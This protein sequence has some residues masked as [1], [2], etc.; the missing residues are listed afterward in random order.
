[1]HN[2]WN[3]IF[4]E[5]HSFLYNVHSMRIT[6]HNWKPPCEQE[7][8]GSTCAWF[9]HVC[10]QANV[11]FKWCQ[12]EQTASQ[13]DRRRDCVKWGGKKCRGALMVFNL[14]WVSEGWQHMGR[15]EIEWR[16]Y[17]RL[18]V[19]YC[20]LSLCLLHS[21]PLSPFLAHYPLYQQTSPWAAVKRTVLSHSYRQ[22]KPEHWP[23]LLILINTR[24]LSFKCVQTL[25]PVSCSS[26]HAGG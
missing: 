22:P 10:M 7:W 3:I 1:M 23:A 9:L 8:I 2:K 16:L 20:S 21:S 11:F 18:G 14:L 19:E 13:T 17:V 25:S 4:F 24:C 5:I 12:A 26:R 15:S 6:T